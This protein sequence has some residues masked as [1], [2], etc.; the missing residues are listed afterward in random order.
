MLIHYD[1]IYLRI[2]LPLR[3]SSSFEERW[4]NREQFGGH[5]L[6]GKRFELLEICNRHAHFRNIIIIK[7]SIFRVY[8][9]KI[10]SACCAFQKTGCNR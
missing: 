3:L 7:V 10:T 1:A 2:Q 4:Y 9:Q 6:E 8:S 5:I